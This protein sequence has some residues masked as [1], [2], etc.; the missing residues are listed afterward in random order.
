MMI[1]WSDSSFGGVAKAALG[2]GTAFL[3]F[4]GLY[5]RPRPHTPQPMTATQE[6][7]DLIDR[8]VDTAEQLGRFS[9]EMAAVARIA[10]GAVDKADRLAERMAAAETVAHD[11]KEELE[12]LAEAREEDS[13]KLSG[14]E[15]DVKNIRSSIT[16]LG[17]LI[18][19]EKQGDG[20][21]H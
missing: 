12:K 11:F 18:R 16:G 8:F 17:T 21:G 20:N 14:I 9:G 1:D 10:Q 4:L 3:G 2:L 19:S 5:L 13:Q 7:K 15:H 6:L